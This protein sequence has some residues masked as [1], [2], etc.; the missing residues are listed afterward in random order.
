[1]KSGELQKHGILR[2]SESTK[3]MTDG[4]L[5]LMITA[6]E[7]L[8]NHEGLVGGTE[9]AV[10]IKKDHGSAAAVKDEPMQVGC[11]CS[12]GCAAWKCS[13]GQVAAHR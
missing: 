10:A 9:A 8:G 2:V 1:M 11:T 5:R 12:A 3:Q 6:A 7:V 4:G 13:C